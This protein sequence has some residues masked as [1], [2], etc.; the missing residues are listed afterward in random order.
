[1]LSTSSCNGASHQQARPTQLHRV[2]R[3]SVDALAGEDLRLAIQRQ[4][5]AVFVDQHMRQQRLGRHAAVD[6]PLRRRRLNDR[7]LAGP[8]AIARPAD[9]PDPQLGRD[10]VQHLGPVFADPMQCTAAARAGLVLDIDHQLDPRQMRRQR[11]AIAF[12][13]LGARRSVRLRRPGSR[14]RRT[15]APPSA[16]PPI[17]PDPRPRAARLRRRAARNGGRSGCVAARRSSAAAARSRP[18]PRAGSAARRPDRRAGL[19]GAANTPRRWIVVTN[20]GQ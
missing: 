13:R 3:S 11:A 12:G 4:V 16:R 17:V 6:R 9:H 20:R 19:A 1:M 2:E 10:V 5:V 8:A 7:F 15:P 14:R 18:V